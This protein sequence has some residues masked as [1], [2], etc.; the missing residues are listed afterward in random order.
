M[1]VRVDELCGV[2]QEAWF[3]AFGVWKNCYEKC[4]KPAKTSAI[5]NWKTSLLK[6]LLRTLNLCQTE[7]VMKVVLVSRVINFWALFFCLF[8]R[9]QDDQARHRFCCKFVFM[10]LGTRWFSECY[11]DVGV[12]TPRSQSRKHWNVR[13]VYMSKKKTSHKPKRWVVL[14]AFVHESTAK[15]N[16]WLSQCQKGFFSGFIAV[17]IRKVDTSFFQINTSEPAAYNVTRCTPSLTMHETV[18]VFNQKPGLHWRCPL[19]CNELPRRSCRF[20]W[21]NPTTKRKLRPIWKDIQAIGRNTKL[22]LRL[23]SKIR[24]EFFLNHSLREASLRVST[25]AST[26]ASSGRQAVWRVISMQWT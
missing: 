13:S 24:S 5:R 15:S 18:R 26:N 1:I 7:L 10:I 22:F 4:V 17:F 16:L 23:F 8:C 20:S 11:V 14:F 6:V 9:Y 25:K 2:L 12:I 19:F 21:L 3:D